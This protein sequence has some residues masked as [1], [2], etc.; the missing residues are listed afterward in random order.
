MSGDATRSA[1]HAFLPP[2]IRS[3]LASFSILVCTVVFFGF[4]RRKKQEKNSALAGGAVSVKVA[5][6]GA[7]EA[8]IVERRDLLLGRAYERWGELDGAKG[9]PA[10][11]LNAVLGHQI[12]GGVV[13]VV[14]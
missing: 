1:I 6:G 5:G 3:Q 7:A 12:Q 11:I 10:H 14:L 4:L 13:L 9:A 8:E 2:S